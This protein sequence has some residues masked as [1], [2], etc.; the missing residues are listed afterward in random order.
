M[1]RFAGPPYKVPDHVYVHGFITVSGEKMSKSRGTGVSLT[2]T[3]TSGSDPEWLRYYIAAKLNA[4][5]E[6]IDFNPDDFLAR[7]EQRPDREV[8]QHR[9]SRGAVPHTGMDGARHSRRERARAREPA[10]DGAEGCRVRA[11]R[12][13]GARA[14]AVLRDAM[15]IADR[16]NEAFDA[17]QPWLLAKNPEP[18]MRCRPSRRSRCKGFSS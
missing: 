1:L 8:R 4:K 16:L 13:R 11:R 6:D 3:S 9:Q 7:G 5:V 17:A 12:L 18:G 2:S 14:G 15:R 10:D